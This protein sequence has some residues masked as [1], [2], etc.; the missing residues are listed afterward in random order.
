MQFGRGRGSKRPERRAWTF[1]GDVEGS[2]RSLAG[3]LWVGT[4]G[5]PLSSVPAAAA[6]PVQV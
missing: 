1:R 5:K 6:V 2:V 4:L 3:G